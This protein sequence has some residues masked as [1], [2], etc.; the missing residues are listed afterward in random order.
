MARVSETLIEQINQI[1]SDNSMREMFHAGGG[2][3]ESAGTLKNLIG[4][5]KILKLLQM[6]RCVPWF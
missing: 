5:F 4:I 2:I 3:G 6:A 1:L